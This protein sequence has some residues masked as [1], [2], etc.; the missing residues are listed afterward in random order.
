MPFLRWGWLAL[1]VAACS[2]AT[3]VQLKDGRTV[4]GELVQLP[5]DREAIVMHRE[6]EGGQDELVRLDPAA[7]DGA[8]PP[9][10]GNLWTGGSLM[11]TGAIGIGATMFAAYAPPRGVDSTDPVYAEDYDD[12]GCEGCF[13]GVAVGGGLFGLGALLLIDG[14]AHRLRALRR[15][16]QDPR[17]VGRAHLLGGGVMVALAAAMFVASVPLLFPGV[18]EVGEGIGFTMLSAAPGLALIGMVVL[19]RG[20]HMR[21][22]P[23]RWPALTARGL[24]FDFSL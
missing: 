1:A 6:T 13:I 16:D 4:T 14:L 2:P 10:T 5:G 9:G 22:R 19:F 15:L 18:G 24:V 3:A 20:V 17:P 8:R 11:L 7:I 12:L 21:V 23:R